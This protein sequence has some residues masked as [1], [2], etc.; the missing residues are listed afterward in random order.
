MGRTYE[1]AKKEQDK[2]IDYII[3]MVEFNH[4]PIVREKLR[5]QLK[6]GLPKAFKIVDKLL[7]DN[8]KEHAMILRDALDYD[9]QNPVHILKQAG[10][11]IEPELEEFRQFLAEISGKKIEAAKFKQ[12]QKEVEKELRAKGVPEE[13][14][15]AATVRYFEEALNA[16]DHEVYRNLGG[17]PVEYI[18]KI[19]N[20]AL[21]KKLAA[22]HIFTVWGKEG[23]RPVSLEEAPEQHRKLIEEYAKELYEAA[24]H[25]AEAH[26]KGELSEKSVFNVIAAN[27][28]L[29]GRI[30]EMT[31]R[32][33]SEPSALVEIPE[34]HR[35]ALKLLMKKNPG[36]HMLRM[37]RLKEYKETIKM[38]LEKT[39][40]ILVKRCE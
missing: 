29:A 3:T 22:E 17:V 23:I 34:E 35:A 8:S 25:L 10:I 27:M 2:I 15:K 13:M 7:P 31:G 20:M 28:S 36:T 32:L 9:V 1:D 5:E 26:G 6:Q 14:I 24:E 12:V 38:H 37:D 40:P 16:M 30:Y 11:D 4:I 18:K 21:A 33:M 39:R 19:R